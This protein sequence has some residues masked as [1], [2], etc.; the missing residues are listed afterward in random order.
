MNEFSASPGD[1][2][3]LT[4]LPEHVQIFDRKTGNNI[5]KK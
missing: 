5:F 1:K 3:Y 2:V 4:I